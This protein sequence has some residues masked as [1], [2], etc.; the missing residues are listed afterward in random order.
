[1]EWGVE[2]TRTQG[3]GVGPTSQGSG[4]QATGPTCTS[5]ST[6]VRRAGSLELFTRAVAVQHGDRVDPVVVGCMDVVLAITDHHRG[7]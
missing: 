2:V 6:T 3:Q 7:R 5:E 4:P 1:M